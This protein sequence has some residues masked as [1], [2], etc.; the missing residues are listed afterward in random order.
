MSEKY[1]I[2]GITAKK[3]FVFFFTLNRR[4]R[5]WE[6]T[7]ILL[8]YDVFVLSMADYINMAYIC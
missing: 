1:L 5:L 4:G 8:K 6:T 2:Y 7:K 3:L